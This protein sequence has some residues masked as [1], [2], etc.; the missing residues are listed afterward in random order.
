MEITIRLSSSGCYVLLKIMDGKLRKIARNLFPSGLV[1]DIY[2][3]EFRW[4]AGG[5]DGGGGRTTRHATTR[6]AVGHRD[7]PNLL[8]V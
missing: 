5:R 8:D 4:I 2:D 3:Q 6:L 7:R 1:L